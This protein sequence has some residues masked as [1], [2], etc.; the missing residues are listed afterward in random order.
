MRIR[1]CF[2]IE[3]KICLSSKTKVK[4]ISMIL[5]LKISISRKLMRIR[6]I[7]IPGTNNINLFDIYLPD[8]YYHLVHL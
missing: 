3:N 7:A 6:L 2:R 5:V 1:D 4:E 8:F